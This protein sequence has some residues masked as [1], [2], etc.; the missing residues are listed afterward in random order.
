MLLIVCE[1]LFFFY[2]NTMRCLQSHYRLSTDPLQPTMDSLQTLYRLSTAL[3]RLSTASTDSLQ[4]LYS[5]LQTLYSLYRPST[6]STD[7]LQ[8]A[9]QTLYS[10]T[11]AVPLQ[12]CAEHKGHYRH[13]STTGTAAALLRY[14]CG[15]AAANQSLLMHAGA[16]DTARGLALSWRQHII[17][18]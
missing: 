2:C 13:Y 11:A 17:T 14:R 15:T 7:S 5:P 9:L 10:H 6:A 3:Y 18:T 1:F 16:L 8:L 4:I 12:C